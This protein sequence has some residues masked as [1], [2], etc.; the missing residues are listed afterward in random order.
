MKF[1]A[2]N[3]TDTVA[4]IVN[5]VKIIRHKRSTTIAANFQSFV[6]S[7]FSSSFLSCTPQLM[8]VNGS[9]G[10]MYLFCFVF[11]LHCK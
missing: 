11:F 10:E 3:S 4:M 5:S 9:G 8:I 7:A 6:I 2:E 1:G